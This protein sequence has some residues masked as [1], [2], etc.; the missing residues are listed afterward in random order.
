MNLGGGGEAVL[1]AE[2]LEGTPQKRG[3]FPLK[4]HF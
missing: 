4:V 2:V 1:L 3:A